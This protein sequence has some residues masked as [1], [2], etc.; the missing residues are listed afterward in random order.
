MTHSS[1][2]FIDP[3]GFYEIFRKRTKARRYA[4]SFYYPEDI[5]KN[6]ISLLEQEVKK[7]KWRVYSKTMDFISSFD[8][9]YDP[10]A[11][12]KLM[13]DRINK[14]MTHFA[15]IMEVLNEKKTILMKNNSD[16]AK[17]TLNKLAIKLVVNPGQYAFQKKEGYIILRQ[18]PVHK[19]EPSTETTDVPAAKRQRIE[20]RPDVY[21]PSQSPLRL[22]E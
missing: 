5:V 14:L 11:E 4:H 7:E 22:D 3:E 13:G 19:E 2:R 16:R 9:Q 6:E 17:E 1:A 20:E 10:L 18:A 21:S 12:C 15:A 8:K